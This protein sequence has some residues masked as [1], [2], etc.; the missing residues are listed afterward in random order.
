TATPI[1][2]IP[3][4][5]IG[6]RPSSRKATQRIED[7]RAIPWSFSWAQC[8]LPLTGWYGVGSALHAYVEQG[9]GGSPATAP[10]RLA[11]LRDMAATW[12]FFA[13]LLSNM[14]QV[15]AKTDLDIARRYAD[16]VE[17]RKLRDA[18]FGQIA[19]EYE[20]TLQM[21]EQVTQRQLLATAPDLE[22]SL[23]A[24]FAYIDPLNHLQVELLRR[25]RAASSKAGGKALERNQRAIHMTI[26]GIA[27][28][29]R[30]SG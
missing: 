16:L 6:S 27:S 2:E 15:L 5:N 7:L 10:A 8:R 28:G 22:A 12:P 23:A 13:T 4:L 19:R 26:N 29:L 11:Q 14:E 9:A 3:G 20:L 25:L 21:F 30:N 24:R 1:R 17:D 18:I